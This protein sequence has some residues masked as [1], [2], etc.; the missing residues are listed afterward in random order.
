[1]LL[2]SSP[3]IMHGTAGGFFTHDLAK[4]DGGGY[5][6]TGRLNNAIRIQG[7]WLDVAD[8]EDKMVCLCVCVLHCLFCVCKR[9]CH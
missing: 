1:M 4:L 5:R 3:V 6:V 8:I 7:V 2:A 9:V